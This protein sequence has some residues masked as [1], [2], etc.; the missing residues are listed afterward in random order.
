VDNW[1]TAVYVRELVHQ[2]EAAQLAAQEFNASLKSPGANGTARAFAA[3]QSLLAAAAM[4]SKMLWPKPSK[5]RFDGSPLKEAEEAQRKTTL[6]RGRTLRTALGIKG[7]P[8][9]ESRKVRN[10]LEHFDDRLDRYFEAGHR[11][12]VD[13]NIGPKNRLAVIGDKPALHLRLIDTEAG[14]VSVLED[15]VPIQGLFD[16]IDDVSNRAQGWL[17]EHGQ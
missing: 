14:T 3:V 15:D 5:F 2:A 1:T 12:V 11:M 10:A 17:T 8:L 16:A 7:S 6:D 4:V 9:L 13:R